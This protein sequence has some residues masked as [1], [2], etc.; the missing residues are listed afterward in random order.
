[1]TD[2]FD[3][4]DIFRNQL[5]GDTGLTIAI[6]LSIIVFFSLKRGIPWQA[7]SLLVILYLS[8]MFE[9]TKIILIWAFVLLAVAYMFYNVIGK[10]LRG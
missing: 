6:G 10:L 5:I 4:W 1:M 3:L 8:I 9:Q 2:I 7:L